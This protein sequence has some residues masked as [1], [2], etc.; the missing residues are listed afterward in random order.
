MYK[1]FPKNNPI[2]Y[3]LCRL[4]DKI[5]RTFGYRVKY[6]KLLKKTPRVKEDSESVCFDEKN[7][8]D[9]FHLSST[10]KTIYNELK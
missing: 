6:G 10:S 5:F 7:L 3:F 8:D 1:I 2:F 4:I 9:H